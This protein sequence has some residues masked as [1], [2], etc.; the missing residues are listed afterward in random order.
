MTTITMTT[1]DKLKEPNEY[2]GYALN[3]H[4]ELTKDTIDNSQLFYLWSLWKATEQGAE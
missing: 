4:D 3:D 1:I 2:N